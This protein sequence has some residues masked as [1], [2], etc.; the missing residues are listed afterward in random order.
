MGL[1]VPWHKSRWWPQ[2]VPVVILFCPAMH[3]V[4]RK[5]VL[6]KN[7]VEGAV[8][9]LIFKN[10]DPQSPCLFTVLCNEIGIAHKLILLNTLCNYL[11]RKHIWDLLERWTSQFFHETLFSLREQQ[12]DYGY[13][14]LDIWQIFSQKWS[15]PV[16]SRKK[17]DNI[18]CQW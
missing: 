4:G 8:K 3:F 12:A 15:T 17:T 11:Q 9:F 14:G 6:L 5:T 13:L 1:L 10:L 7:I 18:W 16:P 2:M